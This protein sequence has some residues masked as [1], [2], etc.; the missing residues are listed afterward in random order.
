MLIS[1]GGY[2][3]GPTVEGRWGCV[4]SAVVGVPVFV[5]L[6][7]ADAL[8]DCMPDNACNK[9]FLIQV[10][11]PSVVVAIAVGL[12]IRWAVKAIRK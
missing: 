5:F 1:G 11:L 2:K 4:A 10:L 6:L 8:G 9:G 3:G 12:L 7:L